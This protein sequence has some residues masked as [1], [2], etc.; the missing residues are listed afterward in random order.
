MER[1]KKTGALQLEKYQVL[2]LSIGMLNI[3]GLASDMT[4]QG[5]SYF[6]L[7]LYFYFVINGLTGSWITDYTAK[8]IK[9]K[10]ARLQYTE[11]THLWRAALLLTVLESL[12]VSG[13][14]FLLAGPISRSLFL[15]ERLSL[16]IRVLAPMLLVSGVYHALCGYLRGM[17]VGRCLKAVLLLQQ[18][19]I[20]FFSFG[21]SRLMKGYGEK[22]AALLQDQQIVYVYQAAGAL[23][24]VLLGMICG[25]LAAALFLLLF[26]SEFERMTQQDTS[27]THERLGSHLKSAAAAGVFP[28]LLNLS[29]RAFPLISYLLYLHTFVSGDT[30]ELLEDSGLLFGIAVPAITLPVCVFLYLYYPMERQMALCLKNR[31]VRRYRDFLQTATTGIFLL[32]LSAGIIMAVLGEPFLKLILHECT[33]EQ[34]L[35]LQLGGAFV[36]LLALSVLTNRSLFLLG[37]RKVSMLFA[38]ISLLV[39]SVVCGILLAATELQEKTLFVSAAVYFLTD[40][41]LTLVFLKKN[42]RFGFAYVRHML[43]NCVAALVS[44]FVISLL[45]RYVCSAWEVAAALFICIILYVLLYLTAFTM[46]KLLPAEM[47]VQIPGGRPAALYAGFFHTGHVS[48]VSHPDQDEEDAR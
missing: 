9:N 36:P 34:L 4:L 48:R 35:F 1:K 43:I 24:G 44:G 31:D 17:G 42:I 11:G 26:H 45:Y 15:N 46:L 37:Y 6:G 20:L 5:I 29:K 2:I 8:Y 21:G 33:A 27:R 19:L 32:P 40:L 28:A 7:T 25:M 16:C 41:V 30:V 12:L 23:G 38:M 14:L 39:Q 10:T 47:L 13:L 3:L 18:I 22:V